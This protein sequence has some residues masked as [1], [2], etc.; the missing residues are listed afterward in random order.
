MKEERDKGNEAVGL[1][2]FNDLKDT[3][4]DHALRRSDGN[5]R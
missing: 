3:V 4:A 5:P 1:A 2:E